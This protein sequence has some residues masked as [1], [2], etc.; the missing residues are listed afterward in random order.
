VFAFA[1]ISDYVNESNEIE[2]LRDL[3]DI[4][5]P[6]KLYNIMYK[7]VK[8]FFEEYGEYTS[9]ET[10]EILNQTI[11]KVDA[12]SDELFEAWQSLDEY[13]RNQIWNAVGEGLYSDESILGTA[14]GTMILPGIGTMIGAYLGGRAAGKR[15][16]EQ[17]SRA[18]EYY[19]NGVSR[20]VEIYD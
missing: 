18:I 19:A 20:F 6:Y 17:V 5:H 2:D 13:E 16:Q 12:L 10:D 15:V 11:S 1:P 9:D 4:Y 8:D 3:L 7:G 14:V